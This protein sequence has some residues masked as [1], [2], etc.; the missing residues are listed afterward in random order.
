MNSVGM[1]GLWCGAQ[2]Y[3]IKTLQLLTGLSLSL[4]GIHLHLVL[5]ML[6]LQLLLFS[7]NKKE[8]GD[9]VRPLAAATQQQNCAALEG[10]V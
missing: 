5:L 6:L 3:C 9:K 8:R 4:D 10:N 7:V 2:E 1:P